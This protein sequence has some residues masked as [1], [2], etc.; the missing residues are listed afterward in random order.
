[1]GAFESIKVIA[2]DVDGVL[3]DGM[4]YYG[5]DG[6]AMKGFSARDGMGVFLARMA[7]IKTCIVT[8]RLS[9]MVERRAADLHIDYV[10]QNISDKEKALET[11]CHQHN[12]SFADIAYMGDDLNDV[13]VISRAR[14]GGAPCDGCLEARQHADFVS[15]YAGGHGALREFIESILK[16]QGVWPHLLEKFKAGSADFT[17]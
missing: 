11:L 15:H 2:F 1:M 17:Q 16:D 8:G 9:P 3:T 7:G 13:A 14:Y 4:L 10:L 6:D 5:P 12:V